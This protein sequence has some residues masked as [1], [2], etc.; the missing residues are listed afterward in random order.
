MYNNK[1]I[2]KILIKNLMPERLDKEVIKKW[3]TYNNKIIE[4]IGINKYVSPNP[5]IVKIISINEI[6]NDI[7]N[8]IKTAKIYE[9]NAID[10]YNL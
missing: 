4:R 5:R 10:E 9:D 7:L 8:W 6:K 2:I 1:D 3:D